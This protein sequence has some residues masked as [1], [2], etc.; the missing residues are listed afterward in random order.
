MS[1]E[2]SQYDFPS[3]PF[4]G[5]TEGP[6]D[7]IQMIFSQAGIAGLAAFGLGFVLFKFINKQTDR[8]DRTQSAIFKRLDKI[9]DALMEC[10]KTLAKMDGRLEGLE[11]EVELYGRK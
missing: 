11:R 2:F 5:S 8:Q 3:P 6:T 9:D 7:I 10:I 4:T 1:G